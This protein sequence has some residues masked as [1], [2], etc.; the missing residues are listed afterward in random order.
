VNCP[1]TDPAPK[2]TVCRQDRGA[3]D[4]GEVCGGAISCPRDEVEGDGTLCMDVGAPQGAPSQCSMGVCC[5]GVTKVAGNGF[6]E[7]PGASIVFVTSRRMPGS[8]G[9]LSQGDKICNDAAAAANLAGNYAA[10]LSTMDA[11]GKPEVNA[12]G[13]IGQKAPWVRI[14]DGE[15]VLESLT[16]LVEKGLI[17]PV[18][19]D[20]WGIPHEDKAQTPV[21]TGTL[22][23]GSAGSANCSNWAPP[24]PARA[25]G[26]YGFAH[27]Y[28]GGLWTFNDQAAACNG[29]A[30]LY[31]F[32]TDAIR[33]PGTSAN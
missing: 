14:N 10:W 20:E 7:I 13:R 9:G 8:F 24:D 32:Q 25:S 18:L 1:P 26:Y 11:T 27:L 23:N 33:V 6:C 29:Q 28:E 16:A 5:P 17:A 21:W 2:E 31:C 19:S 15:V 4:I 12:G 3:C 22:P 30:A